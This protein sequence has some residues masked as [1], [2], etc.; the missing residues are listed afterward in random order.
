MIT[1]TVTDE[2]EIVIQLEA[3][4]VNQSPT[5]F[6]AVVD[7]GF[8][9]CLTLPTDT[10]NK[11]GASA[12]GTRRAELGDGNLVEM[13]VHFVKIKCCCHAFVCSGQE[14]LQAQSAVPLLL[15]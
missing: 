11:L 8:N 6:E 14:A 2:R 9:G 7:I 1:G 15:Q 5:P 10:L 13:D 3:L 12:A 4:A